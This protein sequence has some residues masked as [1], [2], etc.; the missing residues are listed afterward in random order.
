MTSRLNQAESF[1]GSFCLKST[2]YNK[3]LRELKAVALR[4][5]ESQTE[6]MMRSAIYQ[7][8][9]EA[10]ERALEIIAKAKYTKKLTISQIRLL[11]KFK[12]D[13]SLIPWYL[14]SE[15]GKD[16]GKQLGIFMETRLN[17]VLPKRS[18]DYQ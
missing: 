3:R 8:S 2:E 10:Q 6:V 17:D 9:V 5:F 15:R 4:S 1:Y 13:M 16:V 7:K 14:A 11:H 12:I 18:D